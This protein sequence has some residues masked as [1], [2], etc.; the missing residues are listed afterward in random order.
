MHR[1]WSELER[2]LKR[3]QRT[4]IPI[5]QCSLAA[6]IAWLVAFYVFGHPRPFFAPIAAVICLGV[7]LGQRL[8]RV[9]ELVVGVSVG[10]GVGDLLISLIGSGPWQITLVVA[11]A[12]S[13]AVLLDSGAVIALQAGSS[14]VLVATL[15]PPGDTG[16]LDR[17]VDALIGGVVGLLV[18]G[19]L[20]ANPLTVAHRQGKVVLD[21]LERALRG[22]AAA[23]RGHDAA[24]CADVLAKARESHKAVEDLRTGLAAGA[25]IAKIA[26]IRWRRRGDLERYKTAATAVD[27][28][29]RNTRVLVRR[30]LAALRDD[31]PMPGGV[32]DVLDRLADAVRT[33]QADL[34]EGREPVKAREEIYVAARGATLALI[35]EGGFSSRVVLAQLRSIAVDL[36]LATG[37]KRND[38]LAA[39]PPLSQKRQP[40]STVE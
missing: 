17:M 33:L 7:S 32:A 24:K 20:P 36:L 11:L 34:A 37:I 8:R 23:V 28:A 22:V 35:G 30:A 39:L 19:L 5:V 6:G 10:I 13:A 2:R 40:P 12:M 1:V 26:P 25:E 31:E 15:L 4:A 21:E 18:A 27:H 3:W 29:L 14:A 38:A 9:G 16:G